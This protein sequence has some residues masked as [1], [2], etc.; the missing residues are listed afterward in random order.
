MKKKWEIVALKLVIILIT[1]SL[2]GLQ[3][4]PLTHTTPDASAASSQSTRLA[5]LAKAWGFLKY[6][7]P[8]VAKGRENWDQVLIEAIDSVKAADSR[9]AFNEVISEMIGRAGGVNFLY[10]FNL[11][12]DNVPERPDFQWLEDTSLFS[13]FNI[14]RLKSLRQNYRRVDNAYV[15]FPSMVGNANPSGE[16]PYSKMVYPDEN[17]RLL[18]LFRYWNIIHYFFPYKYLIGTDWED[19]LE[20]MIPIFIDA[21]DADQ[22]HLAVFQLAARTEDSHSVTMSQRLVNY[23]GLFFPPFK[24]STIDGQIVVTYVYRYLVPDRDSLREGDIIKKAGDVPVETL[25]QEMDKYIPA[26]NES[27]KQRNLNRYIFRGHTGRLKLTILR[28]GLEKNVEVTRDYN[29]NLVEQ[30]ELIDRG[31][32]WKILEGNIGYVDMGRLEQEHVD[33]AMNDLHDTRAI[34]FDIRKNPLGTP[35]LIAEHLNP[36]S[37]PFVKFT[38]PEPAS[39]GDFF[40][41]ELY[42]C[43]PDSYNENYYKGKVILLFNEFTQS[44]AEFTCMALQTAPRATLI[45]SQTSGAD[46][47]ISTIYLPGDIKTYF[48][49]I[50]VYYPDGSETQRIGIVPDI[51]V[52]PTIRGLREGRDE[53][54]EKALEFINNSDG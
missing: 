49:G 7:H 14:V 32:I 25:I 36:D 47:N 52:K 51:E 9:E 22:Y 35:Y 40:I 46:G 39:P 1:F 42:Y 44:H 19:V 31:P 28:E 10:C 17:Y 3:A 21:A 2:A 26:S 41:S 30:E 12:P 29:P 6:Y 37:V 53:L 45:G 18:A 4:Y 13:L 15:S 8:W 11:L 43:G 54:M 5:A 48:S 24:S 27:S 16:Q 38:R 20:E 34:I 33:N 23:F 50:G